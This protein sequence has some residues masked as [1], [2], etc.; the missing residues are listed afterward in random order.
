MILNK[1]W[2]AVLAGLFSGVLGAQQL[3]TDPN[4]YFSIVVPA[5]L[6]PCDLAPGSLSC[7]SSNPALTITT[8]NVPAGASVEL[9]ALN[10]EDSVRKR[11]NFKMLNK[12]VISVDGNKVIVQTMT[13]NNLGNVTLP[14]VVRTVDAVLGTKTFELEVACNQS[15]CGGFL[16]AFDE[17]I[18]S[19]HMAKNGQKLKTERTSSM[20]GLQNWLKGFTF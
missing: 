9:M 19:L 20:G 4:G 14:V 17:A 18:Q 1:A 7:P 5:A 8:A 11:P 13:F 16:D 15:N 2:V 12:E 6:L 10:A 3:Q